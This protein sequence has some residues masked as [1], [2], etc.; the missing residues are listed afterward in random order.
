MVVPSDSMSIRAYL[1]AR[2]TG[3]GGSFTADFDAISF[4]RS[5]TAPPTLTASVTPSTVTGSCERIGPGTCTATTSSATASGSGGVP[6]Y[7]YAWEYVSGTT[8]TINSPTSATTT[9]TR[10]A[11]TSTFPGTS[12][13][14]LYRC[15]VTDHDGTEVYTSNVTVTTT[16]AHEVA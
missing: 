1:V 13:S 9:F 4:Y 14:G 16:H 11:L 12:Y 3:A 5:S 7:T 2:K 10:S 8:A 6:T 15:K